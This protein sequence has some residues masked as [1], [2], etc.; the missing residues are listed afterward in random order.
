LELLLIHVELLSAVPAEVT[1]ERQKERENV[2]DR[3][4]KGIDGGNAMIGVHFLHA[5]TKEQSFLVR[6]LHQQPSF[7]FIRKIG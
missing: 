5:Q 6:G 7:L 3:V 1:S 2:I 4:T